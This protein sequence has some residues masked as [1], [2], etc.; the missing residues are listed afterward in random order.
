M[1]SRACLM[2]AL[3]LGAPR[4]AVGQT[5]FRG[6]PRPACTGFTVL[7]MTGGIRLNQR[8]G[9]VD[10]SATM[11]YWTAGYV[12]NIG[13][14][15]ALGPAFTITA[16]GDGH[17]YGPVLRYRRWL[18]PASSL[19]F[20]PGIFLGGQDNVA[21]PRF[22]SPT[23]DVAFNYRDQVGLAV[24]VDVLRQARA[25]PQWQWHAGMRVGTWLTPLALVGFAAL[26]AATY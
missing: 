2:A 23:V 18:G 10:R 24:G 5:C 6:H 4:A 17:R 25:G 19:D 11:L 22:P 1:L 21:I 20:T 26:A 3:T 8:P 13:A 14:R 9:Q 12:R 16:D 15:S 7:E